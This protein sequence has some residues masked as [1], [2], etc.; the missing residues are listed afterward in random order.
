MGEGRKKWKFLEAM[1]NVL[2][3]KPS[4][5]PTTLI[6]TSSD[7]PVNETSTTASE[8]QSVDK[9]DV[10]LND[11][12]RASS[13][14]NYSLMSPH[15]NTDSSLFSW[16]LFCLPSSLEVEQ[17]G[18]HWQ[19]GMMEGFVKAQ[20]SSDEMLIKLEEKRMKLK[21]RLITTIPNYHSPYDQFDQ[22]G[23]KKND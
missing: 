17:I 22:Y 12:N 18:L 9:N 4:T 7:D 10:T 2:A 21:E 6:D 16:F 5:H 15:D 20:E 13:T 19:K 1:D 3:D 8:E 23:Q 14:D 11:D